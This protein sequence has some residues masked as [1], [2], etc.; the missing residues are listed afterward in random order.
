MLLDILPPTFYFLLHSFY[1][2]SFVLSTFPSLFVWSALEKYFNN[3]INNILSEIIF[4]ITFHQFFN[5][6]FILLRVSLRIFIF[7]RFYYPPL[8]YISIL[9][10]PSV[11]IVTH[12]SVSIEISL[13]NASLDGIF[14]SVWQKEN[15]FTHFVH[16]LSVGNVVTAS[17]EK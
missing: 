14:K 12:F 15:Y 9:S 3:Y 7:L 16:L 13:R 8:S 5:S 11:I 1:S 10:H 6:P 2:A 4:L 17:L